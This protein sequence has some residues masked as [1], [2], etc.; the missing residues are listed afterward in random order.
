MPKQQPIDVPAPEPPKPWLALLVV[1]LGTLT[2]PLDS[3]V[4]I[5]FPSITRTFGREVQDIRWVVISYVLTY[6][7]LLLIFGK[8]G[9]LVGYRIVFRIGL[10]VSTVG[11]G[12]CAF[13]A[14]FEALLAGRMLQGIGVALILSIAPALTTSLFSE[15]Q[16]TRILGIYAAMTA[17][18]SAVGPLAGGLLVE[19]LG[20]GVVFWARM[21]LVML[22]LVLSPI[23]P[24]RP[25]SGSPAGLDPI[26]SLQ[27][28]AA[29]CA[30]LLGLSFRFESAAMQ[31]GLVALGSVVLGAFLAR[32]SRR[33]V[34]IIRPALFRDPMFSLMNM[35]SIV[36]QL[37]AFAVVLIGPFFLVGI[38]RLETG[39]AGL[40]LALAATGAIVGSWLAPRIIGRTG[41]TSAAALGIVLSAA[42]LFG[43]A[44]WRPDASVAMMAAA[45]I[46]QGVGLGLFQVAYTD[47]VTATLPAADR[48][49]AGSLT[50]LTRTIGIIGGAAGHA[51][52]LAHVEAAAT[53]N[54][55]TT[56][57]AFMAGFRAV[58]TAAALVQVLALGLGGALAWHMRRSAKRS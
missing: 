51:A 56:T 14:S 45:L 40:V 58:F 17:V 38:A 46:V 57:D 44:T 21:P 22:A 28:V 49:V 25:G 20:W 3:A 26:G 15:S 16:R 27:L 31:L 19:H 8:L 4:N 12:M 52:L 35:A 2:A 53:A 48:G 1:C 18:G 33:Q 7:S 42:G 11:L 23:I 43:V 30:I 6:A 10:A 29:L 5:A 36:A 54:G 50:M 41:G 24:A 9:D 34:P 32:Q 39:V 37:A 47:L 55:A 13:A